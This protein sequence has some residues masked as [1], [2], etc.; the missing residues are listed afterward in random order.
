MADNLV[1]DKV[2]AFLETT[3][4]KMAALIGALSLILG[5]IYTVFQWEQDLARKDELTSLATRVEV[6]QQMNDLAIEIV[7]VT[8]MGYEDDLVE[9]TFLVESG[10]ATPM[11]RV[12][13]QNTINRLNALRE[14]LGRL[15]DA[16][17]ELQKT[18]GRV[19]NILTGTQVDE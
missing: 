10:E 2:L 11:D 15:E 6:A 9:L 14:K 17:I 8:I 18:S 4:G 13:H 5:S 12:K 1:M 3:A 16:A 7:S 19:E